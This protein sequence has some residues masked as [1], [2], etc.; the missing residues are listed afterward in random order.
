MLAWKASH[1]QWLFITGKQYSLPVLS[2]SKSGL[3]AYM[4][5]TG[6]F[7]MLKMSDPAKFLWI[8]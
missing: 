6:K 1:L 3:N 5:E 8:F 2:L 7:I 4:V